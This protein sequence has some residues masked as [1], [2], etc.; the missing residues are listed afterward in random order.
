MK[1]SSQLTPDLGLSLHD[2]YT[3]AQPY[4]HI[5]MDNFIPIED[6]RLCVKEIEAFDEWGYDLAVQKQ[7]QQ[8]KYFYPWKTI[9]T[10]SGPKYDI[11]DTKKVFSLKAPVCWK[12]LCYFNSEEFIKSLENLTGIKDLMPDWGFAGGGMHNIESG[13]K[14]AVHSDFNNHP[15]GLGWRRINLLVYLNEDWQ[16]EWG[17]TLQVWKSDMSEMVS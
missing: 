3:K 5:S 6:I 13:G 4:P 8:H 15:Y 10:E 14:L 1:T 17:G 2:T 12:W 11:E 9:N 16:K 7:H